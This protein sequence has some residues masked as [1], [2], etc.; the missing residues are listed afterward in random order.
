MLLGTLA[1]NFFCAVNL[2]WRGK[3][4]TLPAFSVLCN[5]FSVICIETAARVLEFK[6]KSVKFARLN[7]AQNVNLRAFDERV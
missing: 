2:A 5:Q 4:K 3:G 6:F 7:L 1:L